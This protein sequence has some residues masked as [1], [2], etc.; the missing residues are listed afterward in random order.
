MT[1][2]FTDVTPGSIFDEH[3]R[4]VVISPD[5]QLFIH[6]SHSV[7][8]FPLYLRTVCPVT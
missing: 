6:P 7:V 8:Q 4:E 5:S 3:R 1:G 2:S